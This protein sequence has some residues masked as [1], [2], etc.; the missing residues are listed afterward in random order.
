MARDREIHNIRRRADRAFEREVKARIKAGASDAEVTALREGYAKLRAKTMQKAVGRGPGAAERRAKA[1]G[2]LYG[3][4]ANVYQ[5]RDRSDVARSNML[6]SMKMRRGTI[7]GSKTV[8]AALTSGFWAATRKYWMGQPGDRLDAVVR[9]MQR[10][11]P[12]IRTY[13]DAFRA[14]V[15]EVQGNP[16]FDALRPYLQG[17]EG[18]VTEW[19]AV[20]GM[21]IPEEIISDFI[22]RAVVLFR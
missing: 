15:G 3:Y 1:F 5:V 19:D 13:Q 8:D 2:E 4:T 12:A 22:K 7:T 6:F 10:T 11:N 21:D 18:D 16:Q 20:P 9:G 17:T 14:V